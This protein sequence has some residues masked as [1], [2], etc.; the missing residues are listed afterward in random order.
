MS[1]SQ[2]LST[3]WDHRLLSLAQHVAGWSKDPST[4]VGAVIADY[5]HRVLSV[6]FNG[7]PKGVPDVGLFDREHKLARIVH[8]EMNAL[9]FASAPLEGATLYVWPM[10]PCS[11]CAGPIIQAGIGRIV[12]PPA[13]SRWAEACAIGAEMFR[14]ANVM[15]DEVVF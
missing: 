11:H 6:G 2:T 12:S 8:A 14:E 15:L 5:D 10:P 9:L 1:T 4:K 7:Y 13:P 3:S